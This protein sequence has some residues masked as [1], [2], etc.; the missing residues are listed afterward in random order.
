M[1]SATL[2]RV[3]RTLPADL[4]LV[5]TPGLIEQ[6]GISRR[7]ARTYVARGFWSRF[8]HGLVLT[9]R[10]APTRWNWAEAGVLLGG[11]TS[12]VSGWEALDVRGLVAPPRPA[13]PVLVLVREGRSR[14]IGPL[15]IRRTDRPFAVH[16]TPPDNPFLPLTPIAGAARSV[17]DAACLL[18]TLPA[19]RALVARA[20]QRRGCRIEELAAELAAGP[21]VG[22]GHL[23]RA[24]GEVGEGARS[25]AEASALSQLRRSRIPEFEFNVPVLDRA[26]RLLFTIDVLWRALRAAME[27]DGRRYHSE[28]PDWDATLS[29]HNLITGGRLSVT[30][31]SPRVID[32]PGGRWLGE[33]EHWLRGRAAELGVSYRPGSPRRGARQHDAEPLVLDMY[34]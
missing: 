21:R 22:S 2:A 23:R 9:R 18:R 27:I 8:A 13:L 11:S 25:A 12:A 24:L 3:V 20:V 26:G 28:G 29:R 15:L 6:F 7:E 10:G 5:L 31:Y 32:T 16:V 34:S 17:A 4:P 14:R 1:S 33:L 19:V 30:H